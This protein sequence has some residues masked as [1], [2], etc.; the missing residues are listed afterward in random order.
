VF[1]SCSYQLPHRNRY[2]LLS[3]LYIHPIATTRFLPDR[4][5]SSLPCNTQSMKTTWGFLARRIW[6]F[7]WRSDG[8]MWPGVGRSE[9]REGI[10]SEMKERISESYYG[11]DVCMLSQCTESLW[12]AWSLLN[13]SYGCSLLDRIDLTVLID[14]YWVWCYKLHCMLGAPGNMARQDRR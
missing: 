7:L 10:A 11:A 1:S 13:S 6:V 9:E 4:Y 3:L 12:T 14:R 2:P 5:H 8:L